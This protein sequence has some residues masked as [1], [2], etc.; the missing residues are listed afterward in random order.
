[1]REIQ[2]LENSFIDEWFSACN[3][4]I[5]M[6]VAVRSF[7]DLA[8]IVERYLRSAK[9]VRLLKNRTYNVSYRRW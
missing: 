6:S 2:D 5:P 4:N 8:D 3:R 1:M 9:V 7:Q